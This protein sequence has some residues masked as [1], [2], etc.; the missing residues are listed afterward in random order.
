MG[1]TLYRH[2]RLLEQRVLPCTLI[3]RTRRNCTGCGLGGRWGG[4]GGSGSGSGRGSGGGGGG[5]LMVSA[6][7]IT[8]M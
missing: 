8:A 6:R 1:S 4:W 2:T 3:R 7:R 5:G